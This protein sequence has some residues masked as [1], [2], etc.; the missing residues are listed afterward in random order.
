MEQEKKIIEKDEL[1]IRELT[2]IPYIGLVCN[3]ILILISFAPGIFA[4]LSNLGFVFMLAILVVLATVIMPIINL[5][6]IIISVI[7]I[8]K[9]KNYE[10]ENYY[11]LNI[12]SL[13]LWIAYYLVYL[14][15]NF[16]NVIS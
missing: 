4:G 14:Y 7:G 13:I 2:S 5:V 10:K 1:K 3:I 8:I 9:T 6:F 15:F 16:M 12:A 11:Y